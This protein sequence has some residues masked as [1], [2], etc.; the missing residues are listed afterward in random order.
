ML[1][2]PYGIKAMRF[3]LKPM[4][5]SATIRWSGEICGSHYTGHRWMSFDGSVLAGHVQAAPEEIEIFQ[6]SD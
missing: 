2:N 5:D 3:P 6:A 1:K 4:H